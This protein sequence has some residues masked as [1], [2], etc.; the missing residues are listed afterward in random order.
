MK[1]SGYFYMGSFKNQN[2]ERNESKNP[3]TLADLAAGN[4]GVLLVQPV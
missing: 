2:F 4:M 1:I 3:T